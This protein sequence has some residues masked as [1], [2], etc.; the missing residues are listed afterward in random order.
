MKSTNLL[1]PQR[2]STWWVTWCYG[3]VKEFIL[4]T[5]NCLRLIGYIPMAGFWSTL[6][7][8]YG[9]LVGKL[10]ISHNS[11]VIFSLSIQLVLKLCRITYLFKKGGTF[12]LICMKMK[13]IC[14][15]CSIRLHEE[16]SLRY[17]LQC[18][19]TLVGKF[20]EQHVVWF[21]NGLKQT[22]KNNLLRNASSVFYSTNEF[23]P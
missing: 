6:R 18:G 23:C 8:G 19:L 10:V 5:E 16:T 3:R 4:M 20:N 21:W 12:S 9:G 7:H 13:H 2:N 22:S 17:K 14:Y 1:F 15:V 11:N